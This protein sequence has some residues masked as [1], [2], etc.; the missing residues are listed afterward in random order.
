MIT[1]RRV[2]SAILMLGFVSAAATAVMLSRG[3]I[4]D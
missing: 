4:K 1:S 3:E 2:V